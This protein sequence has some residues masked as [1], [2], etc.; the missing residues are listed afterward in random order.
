MLKSKSFSIQ[1]IMRQHIIL[2]VFFVVAI[3]TEAGATSFSNL[4]DHSQNSKEIAEFAVTTHNQWVPLHQLKLVS[5]DKFES[6]VLI[7]NVSVVYKLVLTTADT[8]G[9]AK[10][11]YEAVVKVAN[12]STT[13]QSFKQLLSFLPKLT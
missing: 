8:V 2:A 3:L 1:A 7:P 9:I 10:Q 4:A 12:L 11:R 13:G 5:V 6:K